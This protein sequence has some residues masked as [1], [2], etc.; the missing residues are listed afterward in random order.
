MTS[1]VLFAVLL[2]A[3]VVVTVR[4]V[5]G[6]SS[7]IGWPWVVLVGL[8]GGLV[9]V[10]GLFAAV[11]GA[12][13]AEAA[14]AA[15]RSSGGLLLGIGAFGAAFLLR[16]EAWVR[17][18]PGLGRGQAL[19]GIHLALG[20]NH[21][22]PLRLGEPLRVLSAARRA[23]VGLEAATAS[24]VM[25]RSAD[26]AA[27]LGL[28]LVAGPAVVADL[29][30]PVGAVV[31]A[32][33][34]A[35]G[36]V[37]TWRLGRAHGALGAVPG[38]LASF[39]TLTAWLLEA[40][41]VWQV[42]RLFGIDLT[43][44]QAVMVLA[45]AVAGQLA[46][47]APGG[48]GSYEA[49]A[50]AGLAVAGVDPATG[51]AVAVGLHVVK[52]AYSLL[53]SAVA[54]VVP[55][56]GMLGRLRLPRPESHRGADVGAGARPPVGAPADPAPSSPV[57][58]PASGGPRPDPVPP[59]VLFLPAHDE[60]PRVGGVVAR[61]PA[62]VHGHPVLVAVIDDGSGD[63]TAAVAR[64]AG[65][66]VVVHDAN[67][68]L[69]AAVRTG[70]AWAVEREAVAVAFCDADGEYDPAELSR[71]VGP[72][73]ADEAD[74]VVGSRFAG[75]IQ[76]MRPHRRLGNRVLTWWMR[77]TVQEPV[78]DGQSGYR[79]FAAAAARSARI[80][81]DYNYAQVLTIDLVGQGFRYGEVPITYRFRDSGD[82]FVRLGRYLRRV[83]PTVWRQLNPGA[84]S[85]AG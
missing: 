56:P 16:A 30:G 76:H 48:I 32:V 33:V 15:R 64:A 62:V 69:G 10:L 26:V 6:G 3:G 82:S 45:V 68:G 80:P 39:L 83:V 28:G 34:V 31:A 27:L 78:T 13:L 74:Y 55:A 43:P 7:A 49:A 60:G 42:A 81:H 1:A 21:L 36:A 12:A 72:V 25:L 37:A 46:A 67:R 24:T 79:A 77:W 75:D 14:A 44:S 61:A 8:G 54:V 5:R 66:E 20:G 71:L 35:L 63:D 51:L 50:A 52:T 23:G 19:A 17:V 57:V 38:L 53:V 2:A 58:A 18:L 11:D 47:I 84:G 65:A 4:R 73:L 70:L 41:L 29:L 59:V 40:V 9:A 85:A 22:L